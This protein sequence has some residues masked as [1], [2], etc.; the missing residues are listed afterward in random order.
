[1][2]TQ[3]K[4]KSPIT[5]REEILSDEKVHHAIS[6]EVNFQRSELTLQKKFKKRLKKKVRVQKSPYNF[7]GRLFQVTTIIRFEKNLGIIEMLIV[8]ALHPYGTFSRKQFDAVVRI[9]GIIPKGYWQ[10]LRKVDAIQPYD[11]NLPENYPTEYIKLWTLS[12]N[13]VEGVNTIYQV[14]LGE[15]TLP[16]TPAKK[17]R[18]FKKSKK[19]AKDRE[20]KTLDKILKNMVDEAKNPL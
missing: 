3:Y 2:A 7:L 14:L 6:K 10:K 11:K 4:N 8:L 17:P 12:R 20:A 9:A 15:K 1:M 13:V 5:I 18:N 16:E 19:E